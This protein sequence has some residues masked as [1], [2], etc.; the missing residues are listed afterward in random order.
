MSNLKVNDCHLRVTWAWNWP[1]VPLSPEDTPGNL[2]SLESGRQHQ[3]QSNWA[4][5]EPTEG[6]Q[7]TCLTRGTSSFWMVPNLGHL[8]HKL[9]R[10][11]HC[12]HR[13]LHRFLGS[14]ASGTQHLF[15]TNCDTAETAGAR[16][17]KPCM[18]SSSVSFWSV[19]VYLGFEHTSLQRRHHF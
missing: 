14:M 6:K 12:H 5:P 2:R 11:S 9:S 13:T 17:W 10:C 15:Q 19:L 1:I 7:N 3:F 18:T 4:G 8:S 16:T